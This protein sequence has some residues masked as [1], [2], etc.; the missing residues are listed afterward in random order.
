M[1]MS[2][3]T[4]MLHPLRNHTSTA[5]GADSLLLVAIT[6]PFRILQ[7]RQPHSSQ[8]RATKGN[9]SC[10]SPSLPSDK[11]FPT[12]EQFGTVVKETMK[13]SAM[14]KAGIPGIGEGRKIAKMQYC[15]AEARRELS[16]THLEGSL[17]IA[18]S[19]DKRESRFLMRYRCVGPDLRVHSGIISHS[20][21]VG[22]VQHQGADAVR[23]ATIRGL[24]RLCTPGRAPGTG[25]AANSVATGMFVAIVGKIECF[26]A[27]GAYDEQL[28]GRELG[29]GLGLAGPDVAPLR[30]TLVQHLPALKAT[31]YTSL[32]HLY[33][34]VLSQIGFQ[35]HVPSPTEH[36]RNNVSEI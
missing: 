14:S 34:Y 6:Y 20:R 2:R 29:L 32:A 19:Q 22:D 35:V 7:V 4:T 8:L 5:L 33:N 17:C 11:D 12:L 16:R 10:T 31:S 28:A 3:I 27:D 21:E 25:A 26:A 23:R 30:D 9:V 15:L 36:Q 13:K 24:E 18:I 1:H